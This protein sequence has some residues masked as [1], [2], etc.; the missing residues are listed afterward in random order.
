MGRAPPKS[1]LTTDA[2]PSRTTGFHDK[3]CH[4]ASRQSNPPPL[5]HHLTAACALV[6]QMRTKST[7]RTVSHFCVRPCLLFTVIAHVQPPLLKIREEE[8]ARTSSSHRHFF[9]YLSPIPLL[10]HTLCSNDTKIQ[11]KNLGCTVGHCG[12]ITRRTSCHINLL[13]PFHCT[14]THVSVKSV[15]TVPTLVRNPCLDH[16]LD[17]S[18]LGCRTSRNYFLTSAHGFPQLIASLPVPFQTN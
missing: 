18:H 7:A 3:M 11:Y 13:S 14:R 6:A 15:P 12:H 5:L 17:H 9:E 2:T 4:T 8:S 16:H 1:A 10:H